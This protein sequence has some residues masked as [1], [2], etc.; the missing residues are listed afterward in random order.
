[1]D[2]ILVVHEEKKNAEEIMLFFIKTYNVL[3]KEVQS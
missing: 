3:R 2:L 1:M